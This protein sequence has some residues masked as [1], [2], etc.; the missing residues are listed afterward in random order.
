MAVVFVVQAS[1]RRRGLVAL[2]GRYELRD[3]V[4]PWTLDLDLGTEASGA[5]P[6][7]T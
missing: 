2:L 1:G 4:E 3:P 6:S 7:S 5:A